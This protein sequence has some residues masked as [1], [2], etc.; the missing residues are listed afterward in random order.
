M[1][2]DRRWC[3]ARRP[4][5]VFIREGGSADDEAI[6]ATRRP[7]L[8]ARG[9][10]QGA[11]AGPTAVRR[12]QP[13][14][15]TTAGPSGLAVVLAM[16]LATNWPAARR[17][18]DTAEPSRSRQ[19][20]GTATLGNPTHRSA[21][22]QPGAAGPGG[23]SDPRR[24]RRAIRIAARQQSNPAPRAPAV[25]PLPRQQRRATLSHIA[26]NAGELRGQA[27]VQC[28][29]GGA[30]RP[31]VPPARRRRRAACPTL[32]NGHKTERPK[33]MS[34][35]S[36]RGSNRRKPHRARPSPAVCSPATLCGRANGSRLPSRRRKRHDD[37]A[38]DK[39]T[40]STTTSTKKSLAEQ[41]GVDW[42]LRDAARGAVGVTRPIRVECYADRL[43][44][45]SES[46]PAGNKVIALGP[47]TAVVDRPVH[48]GRLGAHGSWGMAG[49]GMYWRPLLQVH[50]APDAEQR[51][52]ELSALLQGS[53][54]TVERK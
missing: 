44:V 34:S 19:L 21:T 50:V 39:K 52:T 3:I 48:L 51:F 17:R 40:T 2:T 5:A 11:E 12:G 29:G 9:S 37:E 32:Q 6:A 13:D 36:R 28:F 4:A 1:A 22:E 45:V 49:R 8:P 31:C 43:V 23:Y 30:R 38:D 14:D 24:Q 46:G 33:G 16:A 27:A 47:R 26:E 35:A 15:G 10:S 42:G 7:A 18:Q 20:S 41:R 25:T 53:G 54:L